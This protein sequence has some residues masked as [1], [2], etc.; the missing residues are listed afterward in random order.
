MPEN[1]IDPDEVCNL[2]ISLD[3]L[4]FVFEVAGTDLNATYKM[5]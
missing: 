3:A 1:Q 2:V 4:P 5:V